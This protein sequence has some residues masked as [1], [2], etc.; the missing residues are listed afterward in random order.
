MACR[1]QIH[2]YMS[3]SHPLL[4]NFVDCNPLASIRAIH[5]G[6]HFRLPHIVL[7][8]KPLSFVISGPFK[9]RSTTTRCAQRTP[10]Y[11]TRVLMQITISWYIGVMF[12][13]NLMAGCS[14]KTRQRGLQDFRSAIVV[15]AA[16]VNP[17]YGHCTRT[18]PISR[19]PPSQRTMDEEHAFEYEFALLRFIPR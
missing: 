18:S 13:P 15:M 11:K 8:A 6:G 5:F 4:T 10:H 9:S 12:A 7:T 2:P 16:L 19:L 17:C 14:A 1:E 3:S